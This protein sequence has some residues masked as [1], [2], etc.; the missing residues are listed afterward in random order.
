[1]PVYKCRNCGHE[2]KQEDPPINC[3]VSPD[4]ANASFFV[5][6]S[7]Y[8]KLLTINNHLKIKG[9]DLAHNNNTLISQNSK[10]EKEN[11]QLKNQ[12]R[13]KETYLANR[14]QSLASFR[15]NINIL[16]SFLII[17]ILGTGG[18]GYW[19]YT[20]YQELAKSNQSLSFNL[21]SNRQNLT[22]QIE[23][24]NSQLSSLESDKISL[25]NKI[26]SLQIDYYNIL[27]SN[28]RLYILREESY[29]S[30]NDSV[31]PSNKSNNT[32]TFVIEKDSYVD[33]SLYNL[34][35]GGD[36]DFELFDYNGNAIPNSKQTARGDDSLNNFYLKASSY[37]IKV[38]LYS[39]KYTSYT[40]KIYRR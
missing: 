11:K 16:R 32:S 21:Q 8:R 36:A 35:E 31:S 7:S 18:G 14:N 10:L 2:Y 37:Y 6:F 20:K 30:W 19:G 39:D 27:S 22:S 40:L 26:N 34:S 15:K 23:I 29:L 38:W 5:D 3:E 25:K 28:H 33:I 17:T 1:M 13:I 12:T 4:C 9:S 24:L